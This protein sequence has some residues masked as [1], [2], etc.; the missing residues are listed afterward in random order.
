MLYHRRDRHEAV[1]C[2][3]SHVAGLLKEEYN[4]SQDSSAAPGGI[5]T[6]EKVFSSSSRK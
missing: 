5:L 3:I 4:I 2:D 6:M 1:V